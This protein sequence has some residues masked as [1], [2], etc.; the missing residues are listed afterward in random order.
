MDGNERLW[1]FALRPSIDGWMDGWM[2]WWMIRLRQHTYGQSN[3][4]NTRMIPVAN[5]FLFVS[6]SAFTIAIN[7]PLANLYKI[8][9]LT[10]SNT[11]HVSPNMASHKIAKPAGA[12]P[13]DEVELSVAQALLDLE[14]NVPELKKELRPL[15]ISSAK[16]VIYHC[17]PLVEASTIRIP[18][19]WLQFT[20][21][22][23]LRIVSN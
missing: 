17:Q 21:C 14:N 15:Q 19:Y 13:A 4:D 22:F 1:I 8:S 3:T 2:A 12:A 20:N 23:E 7:S 10:F 5:H 11:F 6:I 16:E 18:L 9:N